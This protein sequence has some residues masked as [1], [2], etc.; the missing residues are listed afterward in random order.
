MMRTPL[1]QITFLGPG[2]PRSPPLAES[3]TRVLG[4]FL[5]QQGAR[6]IRMSRSSV[7]GNKTALG[8]F[9]L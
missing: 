2:V 9:S 8:S 4:L 1:L 6:P 5:M 7:P 3:A